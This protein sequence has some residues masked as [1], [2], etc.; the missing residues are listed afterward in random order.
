[1]AAETAHAPA[2]AT[3]YIQHHLTN[4]SWQF[5]DSPFWTLNLDSLLWSV[6]MGVLFLV[7]MYVAARKARRAPNSVPTGL[8]KYVEGTLELI[9][10]QVRNTLHT[11]SPLIAPLAATIFCMVLL[12][13]TI[14]LFPVDWWSTIVAE[15]GA[16][17]EHFKPVATTDPNITIGTALA[18]FLLVQFYSIKMK[19]VAGYGKEFLFHPFNHW[20]LSWFN[21]ILKTV[22]EL[23]R[24]LSL[25][26]R[27]FGNM[28]AGELIM[29]LIGLL[30][31]TLGWPVNFWGAFGW[32]WQLV[33]GF[34]WGMFHVIIVLLQAFIFMMLS[35]VYLAMAHDRGEH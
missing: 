5:G 33:A 8:A 14:D 25:S 12:M 30:T 16:G 24:P 7:F 13:N 10:R 17:L 9:D 1:M 34:G 20:S 26:L 11:P 31:L 18:V 2:T 21:V 19:G 4:W 32:F 28:Y 29:I 23:A 22:E 35:I 27:L 3:E 15:R 6:L